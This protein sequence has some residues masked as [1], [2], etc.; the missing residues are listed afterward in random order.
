VL[1][2]NNDRDDEASDDHGRRTIGMQ[3]I[4]DIGRNNISADNIFK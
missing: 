3:H 2:T 1:I 4:E